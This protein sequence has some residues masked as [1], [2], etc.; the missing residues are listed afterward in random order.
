MY[1]S[2]VDCSVLDPEV[3][4]SIWNVFQCY[5]LLLLLAQHSEIDF[6]VVQE[7]AQ[8][9]SLWGKLVRLHLLWQILVLGRTD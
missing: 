7:L 3:F 4:H 2:L 9:C 8:L 6:V 1:S 5:L